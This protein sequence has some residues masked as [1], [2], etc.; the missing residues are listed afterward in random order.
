MKQKTAKLRKL[1]C[2]RY[3]ILTNDLTKCFICEA[4][5]VDIHEIFGGA[6][7]QASMQHGFCIPLCRRHH[8]IVTND[9]KISNVF[10]EECQLAFENTHSHE[11]FMQI[12]GKNYLL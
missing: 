2:N 6:K 3:S 5:P 1:E 7:R 8:E 10:K 12:I 4:T 9:E 11:E